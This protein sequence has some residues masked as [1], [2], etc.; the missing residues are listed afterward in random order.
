[1]VIYCVSESSVAP[2]QIFLLSRH[3][4]KFLQ[5]PA[6]D[7]CA[8][9]VGNVARMNTGQLHKTK[10]TLLMK[11]GIRLRPYKPVAHF[12]HAWFQASAAMQISS[13]L[14]QGITQRWAVVLYRHFGTTYRSHI[15]ES[16]SS[17]RTSWTW[18][19]KMGQIGCPET[20]VQNY[21]STLR[22]I[23]V[24]SRSQFGNISFLKSKYIKRSKMN[25]REMN[26]ARSTRNA[27]T[28]E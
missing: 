23:S 25:C 26:R 8:L 4:C 28:V 19:L 5:G 1:M 2:F 6:G 14:F 10:L 11:C 17:R 12:V 13:A 21:Y 22:N 15:Q 27:E 9:K 24:Q 3:Y 20:S 7:N 18:P 16:R